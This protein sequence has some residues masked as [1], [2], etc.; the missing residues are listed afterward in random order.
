[1]HRLG[2][3]KRMSAR[4]WRA[5]SIRLRLLALA[6]APLAMVLPV[7]VGILASWGS[8]YF[9]RLMVTKVRSDLAV[10]HGYFDRVEAGVGHA[11]Q[12]LA[13]SERLARARRGGPNAAALNALLA[14]ARTQ[15]QLDFLS[16][17]DASGCQRQGDTTLCLGQWPVVRAAMGGLSRTELDVFNADTLSQLAPGLAAQASIALR[18]T[19]DAT[20]TART[21]E[22]RGLVIHTAAPVLDSQGRLQGVL[23]G[24]I[25][26]NRNL[27]FID[28]LN[29]VVYPHEALPFGSQGTAT[30][31]LED[32]RV[33]TNV[34]LFA[35]ERAIG[36][37]VSTTVNEAVL[38]RGGVWLDRAFV[39]QDWYV[40]G[41]MP[42]VDSHQRRVGMLYVGFLE[43][44]LV[45]AKRAALGLV[46]SLFI[47]VMG[48]A[49][50]LA[51]WW[52]RGIYR[53]IQQMQA[54]M[55][56]WRAGNLTARVG[57]LTPGDEM[58]EL[59]R[60][61]DRL[62]DQLQTQTEA[63]QQWGNALDGEV[64]RR[65]QDLSQALAELRSAQ[66][67]LIRQEKLAA[68]GQ[69][70]AG[71][72]HEINNPVAVI[73]GNLDILA[74]VLGREGC[75][76]VSAEIRLIR[77]QVHRIRMI[78][79]KLLQFARPTDYVG[80]LEPIAP[81]TLVQDSLLLVGHLLRR[82]AIAVTQHM[83]SHRRVVSNKG[84]LQQVLINLL[85]N[86]IQAMP[87]GGVLAIASED[88]D[89]AG[90]PVGICLSVSDTGAGI[91][92]EH[93]NK[94][95]QPFFTSDKIGGNGLGLWV[96]QSIVE[97]YGGYL[98][99]ENRAEGGSRFSIWLRLEPLG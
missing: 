8:E 1:M 46:V 30:L 17:L 73:Q 4:G 95:F 22:T 91:P 59:A 81:D 63:L 36:T 84:E 7:L 53:P 42:L 56:A 37:R 88:W 32:V 90:M 27:D 49:S 64:A 98:S 75:E 58:A 68:M 2:G 96:S 67:Q 69:L 48:G 5:P 55:R 70:T 79:A 74:D 9:D 47:V 87:D 61:F 25:L 65:T 39:V 78:V 82:T 92:P 60:H 12:A 40:S 86:A 11:V 33:A 31:F 15:L 19:A 3:I 94:L 89:E 76:P 97:R 99:A 93:L 23:A 83:D 24:G 20:P 26:L 16:Y 57:P 71:V 44:P 14:D 13:G 77:E 62:L 50:L 18:P 38:Q 66:H 34:R 6:L 45:R 85:V 80:Y 28:H 43:E 35:G 52:A 41:Y 51:A 29:T 21:G 54:T 72:A 10:A